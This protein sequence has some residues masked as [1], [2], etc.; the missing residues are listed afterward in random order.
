MVVLCWL[1][2]VSL[3]VQLVGSSFLALVFGAPLDVTATITAA[4]QGCGKGVPVVAVEQ[5]VVG[6][7]GYR[8]RQGS[9]GLVAAV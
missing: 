5:V 9:G 1:V 2:G 7:L 3:V 6:A 4:P 8:H